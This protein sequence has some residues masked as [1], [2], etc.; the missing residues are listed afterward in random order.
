MF[1]IIV[2]VIVIIPFACCISLRLCSTARDFSLDS[3][4]FVSYTEIVLHD[5]GTKG[6][7]LIK[8]SK[9]KKFV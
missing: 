8:Q 4:K 6:F 9:S 7:T 5:S 3:S 1:S 2:I